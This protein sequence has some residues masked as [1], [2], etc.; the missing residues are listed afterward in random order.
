MKVY[1]YC[2][3]FVTFCIL[4]STA[5]HDIHLQFVISASAFEIRV[6][7]RPKCT[8]LCAVDCTSDPGFNVFNTDTN[9]FFY[10]IMH[11]I[12]I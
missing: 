9:V 11:V 4:Q 10:Y 6:I 3:E 8:V 12:Y 2:A 1:Q 5:R 7:K